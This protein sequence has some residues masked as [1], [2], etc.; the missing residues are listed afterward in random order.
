[1][2]SHDWLPSE[3]RGGDSLAMFTLQ[4]KARPRYVGPRDVRR[5]HPLRCPF[6]PFLDKG[7]RLSKIILAI[8][9]FGNPPEISS[10]LEL[11]SPFV[12]EYRLRLV[13]IAHQPEIGCVCPGRRGQEAG[14]NER[15]CGEGHGSNSHDETNITSSHSG[16]SGF[17]LQLGLNMTQPS[18]A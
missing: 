8:D 14:E 9:P 4:A 1:M 18:R 12:A 16:S 7:P 13:V 17:C 6:T 2:V 11:W 3:G 15:C 10:I 5:H